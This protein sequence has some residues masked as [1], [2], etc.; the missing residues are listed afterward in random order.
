MSKDIFLRTPIP[1]IRYGIDLSLGERRTCL[2]ASVR[3]AGCRRGGRLAMLNNWFNHARLSH[4]KTSV[5]RFHLNHC[6]ISTSRC[7]SPAISG[8]AAH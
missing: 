2:V 3:V 4:A 7:L 5:G 6:A 8:L 1:A